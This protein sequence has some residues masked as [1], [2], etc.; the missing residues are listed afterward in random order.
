MLLASEG[1][2]HSRHFHFESRF[3]LLLRCRADAYTDANAEMVLVHESPSVREDSDA[4][5]AR[6][7]HGLLRSKRG[8][9]SKGTDDW[10]SQVPNE[11]PPSQHVRFSSSSSHLDRLLRKSA[12]RQTVI[13]ADRPSPAICVHVRA[14]AS[15][16]K[17]RHGQG[18]GAG[19]LLRR[20]SHAG[21]FG[22]DF[23]GGKSD[24]ILIL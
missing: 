16:K 17:K 21:T 13:D 14:I 24:E 10:T 15:S 4:G 9:F 18:P 23:L 12:M 7:G 19:S 11:P 8:T 5:C 6:L 20:W 3:S 1:R 22:C 2:L